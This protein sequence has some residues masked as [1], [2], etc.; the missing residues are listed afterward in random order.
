MA[1]WY[2]QPPVNLTDEQYH[3]WQALLEQ[4]AGICFMQ[5]KSILQNG[6]NKRMREI[7]VEDYDDY[8]KQV[9]T[10]PEGVIEWSLLV[11]RVSVKETSFFR[12]PNSFKAVKNYLLNRLD[13][14]I[15]EQDDTLEI[16]SV[17]CSTGEEPYSLAIAA[18]DIADYLASNIF[19]GVTATDISKTAL[20]DARKGVYTARK[21]EA[22]P[23]ETKNKYFT[24]LNDKQFKIVDGLEE[25][26]CFAQSNIL[27]LDGTASI[28]LDIIYCQNV[29][30]YFQRWRHQQV[31][32]MFV[33]R[34]KPGGLLVMGPGE[35]MSWR[36]SKV[37]RLADDLV[38][39]YVHTG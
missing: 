3:Q 27:E 1:S 14:Q 26:L 23:L 6:L 31:L 38:Q 34:L 37:S 29:L 35:V 4:R 33:D 25:K 30:I 24:R 39:A 9:S 13:P 19:I 36:N 8:F 20:N 18:V 21:V 16:W 2:Y 7:G 10:V 12:D 17:G 15:R 22:L 28:K 5:H 11:D 32:D